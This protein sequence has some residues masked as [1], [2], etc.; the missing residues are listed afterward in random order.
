MLSN[1]TNRI[2][3]Q[4]HEVLTSDI[5]KDGQMVYWYLSCQP[6]GPKEQRGKRYDPMDVPVAVY[7]EVSFETHANP[8]FVV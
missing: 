2:L 4:Q 3:Y 7:L 8:P 1:L 6:F 5:F